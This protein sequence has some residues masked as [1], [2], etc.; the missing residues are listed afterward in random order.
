[1]NRGTAAVFDA[2]AAE[3]TGLRDED[4]LRPE[5]D[6]LGARFSDRKTEERFLQ[7]LI[8]EGFGREKLMQA[9]GSFVF[10]AYGVLDV[11]VVGDLSKEFLSVRFF[12]AAP[13]AIGVIC[14]SWLKPLR[15]HFGLATAV[16]LMIYAIAIV[17][18]IYRLPGP[19]APPYIIGVLVVLIFTSCLMRI[20]FVYAGPT[21]AMIAVIYCFALV[22]KESAS[23]ADIV[24]G[25]FFMISVT[26]VAIVTIY[27]QERRA[28]ETWLGTELRE[29]DAS[30]IRQLLLE[31][32]AADRSK[33]NFLSVVT[34]E[35]RTPLHQIIGFSEVVRGQ[36]D[37]PEAPKYLDQITASAH[38]L[39]KKLSKMLRYA[40]AAA[41]KL[42]VELEV[43]DVVDIIDRVR[44]ET[45]KSA[46]A[47][48]ISV[49]TSNVAPATLFVDSH[50]T[51]YALQ[52]I[53]E[54]AINAGRPG[55]VVSI[56]GGLRPSGDYLLRII[57]SGAGMSD[58]QI[59]GAFLPFG[60]ADA[61]LTRYREGLGLGL[62]IS[63][64]LLAEQKARLSIRSEAGVGTTVEVLFP[65]SESAASA[66]GDVAA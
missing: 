17:Y 38:E 46:S 16:A 51:A 25:Y 63:N 21:Y 57:D 30:L 36:P 32:T 9:L 15:R 24:S 35:L 54:N 52:N 3:A 7:H 56:E 42:K 26:G 66:A 60:Q 50:H 20:N 62:P 53:V 23:H 49:E 43:C 34:H 29:M 12:I 41:G 8:A 48:S 61:G 44:D 31:A 19:G 2:G 6:L 45:R 39:L 59:A 58:A 28:R 64:R 47:R 22:A 40:D 55:S 1:M 27:L 14:L 10:V 18:M 65:K 4:A 13:I 5:M 37:L 11:L 33:T